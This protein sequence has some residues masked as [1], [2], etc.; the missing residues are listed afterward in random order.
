MVFTS[1]GGALYGNRASVP[2]DEDSLPAP[3]APY[4]ASKWAGE[5]YLVTWREASGIP[6][7]ICRL[8][9]VYGPRQSPH[10]E[11]GVVAIF[12]YHLW[13]GIPPKLF[14][15]GRPTRDYVHVSDVVA[16]MRAASG[17]GGIYNVATGIERDVRTVFESLRATAGV[18]LKPE[19]APLRSGRARAEL[20]RPESRRTGA[21]LASVRRSRQRARR[22]LSCAGRRIC[23]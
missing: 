5:A 20:S 12:S 23:G 13:Q 1:T 9:N 18:D 2:T 15:E 4:G 3:E 11:A 10:G 14:G 17:A 16:A 21:G 7:S 22:D 8:G 19:L 6:H